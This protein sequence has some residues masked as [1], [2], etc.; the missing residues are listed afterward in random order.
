MKI[1]DRYILKQLVI[2]FAL[3]LI[4]MTVLVWL[5]QSLKM[6]DMMVTKG[7]SVGIFIQMTLLV[8]P[9]FLQV[10]SPLALF[11]VILFIFTRMQSDKELMVMKAVGMSNG[12]IIRAPLM[13]AVLLT[14]FGYFFTLILVPE[15]NTQMREMRWKI[16]NDLSHLMLQEG[17][18]NAFKNGLTI[19]VKER[20]PEGIVKGIIVYD[21]QNPEKT[22][23]LVA[24][25]GI[26]FQQDDRTQVIF[27][28]GVRQEITNATK[29]FSILKFDKYTML[30]DEQKDKDATRISDVREHPLSLL[31]SAQQSDDLSASSYHK[32]K[33]EATRRLLQPI[34][35]IT[36]ALLAVF[37][38]LAG[39]YNRRGQVGQVNFVILLALIVQSLALAFE[40]MSSKNLIF[41]PLMFI[42]VFLPILIVY[43]VLIRGKKWKMGALKIGVVILG[44]FLSTMAF[45]APQIDLDA[46]DKDKP[47]DFEADAIEYNKKTDVLTAIGNVI[48][49]QNGVILKTEKL[50]FD[51]RK[52][53]AKVPGKVTIIM[54]D[55]S[56]TTAEDMVLTD[57]LKNAIAKTMTMQLYDG[58]YIAADAM[59][60]T[61]NGT[62][63]YLR[64]LTYTPCDRCEGKAPLWQL[65]AK[66]MTHDATDKTMTYR[67]SFLEVK[68][69]PIFYFPY[70]SMPDFSVKRKTGFLAPAL[71]H[72]NTMGTGL[73]TPFFIDLA[74]NQ[75]LT[76]TPTFAVSHFPLGVADYQGLFTRGAFN[77]QLSG[78]KD[79]DDR[80]DYQGH[81]KADFEYDISDT[82][83]AS[84]QLFRSSSDTYFRKYKIP[85]I[86][87]NQS[88]LDSNITAERFG[89]RNYFNFT[90]LSFQSLQAGV[91]SRSVPLIIP[92]ARYDYMSDP[93]FDSGLYAFSQ[94]DG[95]SIQNRERFHSDRL[96]VTQGLRLPHVS[97]QGVVF[98]VVGTVRVDGYNID[99]GRYSLGTQSPD[100]TYSTGRIYPNFSV[101]TS[102]PMATTTKNTTQVIR[103]I[104]MAVLSPVGGNKADK[105]PDT[106]SVV[107]DFDDTNLFSRNR[108]TGYDRVETGTRL[109]YGAEW[110]VYTNSNAAFSTLFG[111]SYRFTENKD[112]AYLMGEDKYFSDYVGRMSVDY[113][114]ISLAYRFR[115]DQNNFSIRKNEVT[116]VGGGDPLRL[117]IDYVYLKDTMLG[118][119]F[120]PS[121]EEILIFGSSRLTKQWSLQGLY[122]Y[123]LAH[124]GGPIELGGT[125]RY[126]N[127]CTAILF[128]LSRDFT[129]DRDYKGGTSFMVKFILKTLGGV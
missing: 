69:V 81:V 120:Y 3:V 97:K 43:L 12:Q 89:T 101:E 114:Y 42:N 113:K 61:E 11:A 124:D 90:G 63:L 62:I 10:L 94:I 30:F 37:G 106:D 35:N 24:E 87:E 127:E 5:T 19:Y 88:I 102:Y 20:L 76:I 26:I 122:R 28:K 21:T 17:Q 32:Y 6:I 95:A 115:L 104:I 54:P 39:Y 86:N 59:Q 85:K 100:S 91:N 55:N 70:V 40:N 82:W 14:V 44:L 111:Q 108:Y 2:G 105:I 18:F 125:L 57:G 129:K 68:D 9:N 118:D 38:V 46:V 8:L 58:T 1:L 84:G 128:D 50:I 73:Q 99:T 13:L 7:V 72:S 56:V 123:D 71:A 41:L 92:T 116:L 83:R 75:N 121:K 23:V 80:K 34:Y 45:A 64:N 96:S 22:S 4:S 107:F 16:K 119:N 78:T 93:L 49:N 103:P 77:M 79:D 66:T 51:R 48:V 33:V 112:M 65:R 110:S 98:D 27:K 74:D 15:A 31:L 29:Q 52:D 53:E 60:R 126:D 109:N 47:V 36:F 67:D 25:E 117:G